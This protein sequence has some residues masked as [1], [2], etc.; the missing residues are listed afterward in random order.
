MVGLFFS[1]VFKAL[2]DYEAVIDEEFDFQAGDIIAVTATP[3]DGWWSGELLDEQRRQPGRHVFPSNFVDLLQSYLG[4]GYSDALARLLST[5]FCSHAHIHDPHV[6]DEISTCKDY[7]KPGDATMDRYRC[8]M[9]DSDYVPR[10]LRELAD[11]NE[12]KTRLCPFLREMD[13]FVGSTRTTRDYLTPMRLHSTANMLKQD[14][15]VLL[16]RI[17]L[18]DQLYIPDDEHTNVEI[19]G[20]TVSCIGSLFYVNMEYQTTQGTSLLSPARTRYV[21]NKMLD[22]FAR[23]WAGRHDVL[24]MS[25]D[26]TSHRTLTDEPDE[27]EFPYSKLEIELQSCL[28]GYLN[29]FAPSPG[30]PSLTHEISLLFIYCMSRTTHRTI[31]DATL[32][33]VSLYFRDPS[34]ASAAR[35]LWQA[36]LSDETDYRGIL[37]QLNMRLRDERVLDTVALHNLLISVHCFALNA[38]P[39]YSVD[40]WHMLLHGIARALER[41]DCRRSDDDSVRNMYAYFVSICIPVLAVMT[42][43]NSLNRRYTNGYQGDISK[44]DLIGLLARFSVPSLT[45]V[46]GL[47]EKF[48]VVG[49]IRHHIAVAA[50]YKASPGGKDKLMRLAQRLSVRTNPQSTTDRGLDE[51]CTTPRREFGQKRRRFEDRF[52]HR[53]SADVPNLRMAQLSLFRKEANAQLTSMQWLLAGTLLQQ[54]VPDSG[55][56]RWWTQGSLSDTPIVIFNDR[57]PVKFYHSMSLVMTSREYNEDTLHEDVPEWRERTLLP[58][59]SDPEYAPR[60]ICELVGSENRSAVLLSFL[61]KLRLFLDYAENTAIG[62]R[63]SAAF[64]TAGNRMLTKDVLDAIVCIVM[65]DQR[66]VADKDDA[67]FEI[68]CLGFYALAALLSI[69]GARRQPEDLAMHDFSVNARTKVLA[70]LQLIWKHRHAIL[71]LPEVEKTQWDLTGVPE[72]SDLPWHNKLEFE[73]LNLIKLYGLAFP[74][75][76]YT[77]EGYLLCTYLMARTAYSQV[78]GG[79]MKILTLQRCDTSVVHRIGPLWET[80][81]SDLSDCR[82]MLLQLNMRIRD[83]DILDVNTYL[84]LCIA[85]HVTSCFPSRCSQHLLG[86]WRKLFDGIVRALQRQICMGSADPDDQIYT[87]V[88]TEGI[89]L[90]CLIFSSKIQGIVDARQECGSDIIGLLAHFSIPSLYASNLRGDGMVGLV[91]YHITLAMEY[92]GT[93]EGQHKFNRLVRRARASVPPALKALKNTP[94]FSTSRLVRNQRALLID[95]WSRYARLLEISIEEDAEE[96]EVSD[97]RITRCCAWRDCLCRWERKPAHKLRVCNGCWQVG[98]LRIFIMDTEI[99]AMVDTGQPVPGIN[100]LREAYVVL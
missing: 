99:G 25:G 93:K 46:S 54:E 33:Y 4:S 86:Q 18:K 64:A 6:K 82:A 24:P 21:K 17:A 53:S 15:L 95:A 96:H 51:L 79:T 14:V 61:R 67:E 94:F 20:Y 9:D 85:L 98:F 89:N 76:A 97:P 5:R 3:E 80:A 49:I 29:M 45:M 32:K 66:Y 74:D 23:I 11:S 34:L 73:V 55:L 31:Y 57:I 68:L 90:L 77:D 47:P 22:I 63:E 58:F 16:I 75:G 35:P 62:V 1:T 30:R 48:G 37:L 10:T 91:D 81:M 40:E 84:L 59:V 28:A 19:L 39:R 69:Y 72:V 92:K 44:L 36:A 52:V 42:M 83:E 65:K 43:P 12:Y 100:D 27:S 60:K 41:H 71:P 2:Y 50:K 38:P 78:Y 7:M 70:V 87:T 13:V 8:F 56:A 88:L 26:E